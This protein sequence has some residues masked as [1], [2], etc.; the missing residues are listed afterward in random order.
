MS[1]IIFYQ[2]WSGLWSWL[3]SCKCQFLIQQLASW[4]WSHSFK[5]FQNLPCCL[6]GLYRNNRKTSE[7]HSTAFQFFVLFCLSSRS[8]LFCLVGNSTHKSNMRR[9]SNLFTSSVN[10]WS[11]EDH[12]YLHCLTQLTTRQSTTLRIFVHW[13]YLRL[14]VLATAQKR[15]STLQYIHE[16]R[17]A[18]FKLSICHWE[19]DT[20]LTS[21]K[22]LAK[23]LTVLGFCLTSMG[24][25]WT[26]LV[27][28]VENWP[29]PGLFGTTLTGLGVY[30]KDRGLNR[31]IGPPEEYP[32][33]SKAVAALFFD[34]CN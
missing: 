20:L 34:P 17:I 7:C 28:G 15:F 30:K 2:T 26:A 19:L 22:A 24:V 21:D 12:T 13:E 6:T 4:C 1:L 27:V 32:P 5:S 31:R 11:S 29:N 33:S 16:K 25:V 10:E 3:F 9:G 18:G 14:R 8:T 23:L